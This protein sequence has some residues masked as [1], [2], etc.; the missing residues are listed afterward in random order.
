V[1]IAINFKGSI[2]KIEK[3]G[4]PYIF[5]PRWRIFIYK[6]NVWGSAISRPENVN[7]NIGAVEVGQFHNF[8][9]EHL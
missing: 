5:H 8:N 6:L 4:K 3:M 9:H 1:F 2:N 7:E